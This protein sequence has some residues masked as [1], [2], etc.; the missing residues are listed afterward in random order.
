MWGERATRRDLLSPCPVQASMIAHFLARAR[1]PGRRS[2]CQLKQGGA[3]GS[4]ALHGRPSRASPE[5]WSS[6]GSPAHRC[7]QR[8]SAPVV[9]QQ[10]VKVEVQY[11][12]RA[13][14]FERASCYTQ[15]RQDSEPGGQATNASVH[16]PG[17]SSLVVGHDCMARDT[18]RASGRTD[19][20]NRSIRDPLRGE[21]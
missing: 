15:S 21:K 16:R 2:P 8:R 5:S 13:G 1:G 11:H 4:P 10:E 20:D 18:S 12:L 6:R 19:V 17:D 3:A 9:A 7:R 14:D